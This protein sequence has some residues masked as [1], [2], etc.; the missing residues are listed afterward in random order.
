[1]PELTI[2]K[3][4][5]IIYEHRNNIGRKHTCIVIGFTDDGWVLDSN[6]GNCFSQ[7]FRLGEVIIWE[8]RKG[9]KK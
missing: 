6:H 7:S 9:K 4:D 2:E 3:G 5:A 1:M 8:H